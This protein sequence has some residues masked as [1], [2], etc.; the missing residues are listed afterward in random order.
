MQQAFFLE[1][2][3]GQIFCTAYL[4]RP[5]ADRRAFLIIPPFGEEMNKSRHV[6]AALT[7]A[8]GEAGHDVLFADFYGTG[9]SQGDFGDA[10]I[11]IWRGDLDCAIDHLRNGYDDDRAIEVVGLRFGALMAAELSQRHSIASLALV[12][13]IADGRQQLNQLLRLRIAAGLLGD[14]AKETTAGLR[15]QFAN[16]D[17][18]E[19]AG[20]TVSAEMANGLAPLALGDMCPDKAARVNWIELVAQADRPLMPVS[21][22]LIDAWREEGRLV[23]TATVV[24]DPFWATQEIARCPAVV[25]SVLAALSV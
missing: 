4:H 21:Q 8:L 3:R 22:R 6:L 2:Y 9:D 19:I 20:Y 14:G 15:E 12:H 10:S 11:A 17:P 7:R 25:E 5:A 13:P 24:C 18:L 23:N 1:G 16:G